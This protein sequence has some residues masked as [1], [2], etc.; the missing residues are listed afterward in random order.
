MSPVPLSA[1]PNDPPSRPEPGVAR[2]ADGVSPVGRPDHESKPPGIRI[3]L[4]EDHADTRRIMEGLL[5]RDR[6]SVTSA[7]SAS[8]ALDLAATETFDLVISD[9]GLPD[10]TGTELM[11]ELRARHGLRGIAVSGYAMEDDLLRCREAGFACH[12]TKPLRLDRLRRMILE[13][14]PSADPAA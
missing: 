9:L 4:V 10:R 12:L 14:S 11:A 3:L 6:H 1:R 7:G 5:R 13:L 8:E 2:P